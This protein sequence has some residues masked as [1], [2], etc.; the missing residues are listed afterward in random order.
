MFPVIKPQSAPMDVEEQERIYGVPIF[1]KFYKY[2]IIPAK[3]GIPQIRVGYT[4][5]HFPF[6][7][8]KYGIG[9]NKYRNTDV[10][11]QNFFHLF[12]SSTRTKEQ[13]KVWAL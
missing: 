3:N 7:F 9:R 4:P 1:L 12:S 13:L 8:H 11:G 6:H 5:S 2:R 10:I